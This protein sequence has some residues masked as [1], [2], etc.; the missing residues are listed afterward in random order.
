MAEDVEQLFYVF[1]GHLL[2][3]VIFWG[4]SAHFISHLL[5]D[6]FVCVFSILSSFYVLDV[7]TICE[8]IGD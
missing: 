4:Q 5:T 1:P 3:V 7:S 8:G 6:L 2:L